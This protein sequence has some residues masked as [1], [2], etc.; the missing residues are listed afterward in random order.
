MKIIKPQKL[1]KGDTI[2]IIAPA[3]NTDDFT[4]IEK[5]VR[6]F[7]SLSYKVKLG[8]SIKKVHG[9]L[10]G[11]DELRLNDI[12]EM[13]SDKNI[14]AIFCVRGGYGSA[15]LLNKIDY[16]LIRKNPKIFVG[17]SDITALQ[18]A[19]LKKCGLVTF[20][21]PMVAVD[22]WNEV[23]SFTEENFW[24]IVTSEKSSGKIENPKNQ[25]LKILKK[26]ISE[27]KLIGGNLSLICSLLGTEFLP[28]FKNK[29]LLLEEVAE[30]PYKIDRMLNQLLLSK[31][32]DEISGIILGD[33][34]DCE[35]TDISKKTLTLKEVLKDFVDKI[36][37]PVISNFAHGHIKSNLTMAFGI[38]YKI[39]AD[40]GAVEIL[41]NAVE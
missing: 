28:S 5:G 24:K 21:G 35:E 15:R 39:D 29:I 12:H 14:K 31:N 38:N 37:V 11:K 17:Y 36:D 8:K 18:M 41:E 4:R 30:K 20:A 26:G 33:F 19:F 13:F 2:G 6:Y 1:Q 34:S 22:F 7:E 23:N 9:Y 10:A 40:K 32:L 3:S 16:N 25:K 27:G